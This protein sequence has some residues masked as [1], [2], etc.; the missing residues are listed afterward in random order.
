MN[1]A[2]RWQRFNRELSSA[3]ERLDQVDQTT[4][5][6]AG[7]LRA[8]APGEGDISAGQARDTALQVRATTLSS[9]V[10]DTGAGRITLAPANAPARLASTLSPPVPGDTAWGLML[11]AAGGDRWLPFPI[12]AVTASIGGCTLGGRGILPP[13]TSGSRTVL[14][15]AAGTELPGPGTVV[16]VTRL[17][18]Y[19]L[20]RASDNAWYLGVREWNPPQARFNTIQPVSGPFLPPA[21]NGLTF[22][23]RDSLDAPVASGALDTRLIARVEISISSDSGSVPRSRLMGAGSEQRVLA[24][25]LRNRW[26]P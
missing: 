11:D 16:R 2:T 21:R 12:A 5:L 22:Q 10:C 26:R 3:A 18:R 15:V 17:V 24:V 4:L 14:T 13:N 1:A 9:I 20:Y 25:A 7:D 19:S 6:L 23:Y 8:V